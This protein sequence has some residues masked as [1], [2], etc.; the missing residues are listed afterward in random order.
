MSLQEPYFQPIWGM[1]TVSLGVS[2]NYFNR[3]YVEWEEE[4]L[5]GRLAVGYPFPHRP[6]LSA[7]F[8]FRGARIRISNPILP[9]PAELT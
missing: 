9:T 8:A 3:R 2:G 4:R 5:G 6:D 7:T 1:P